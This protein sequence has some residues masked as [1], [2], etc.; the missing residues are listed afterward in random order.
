MTGSIPFPVDMKK[1]EERQKRGINYIKK[2]RGKEY[3]SIPN[4]LSF[5]NTLTYEA[6]GLLLY[7]LAKPTTWICSNA[8]LMK[9]SPAGRHKVQRILKELENA[10]YIT[11]KKKKNSEGMFY[12]ETWIYDYPHV[13]ESNKDDK[14]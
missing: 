6:R 2:S 12:Y 11:R 10:N 3:A 5:D 7:L 4:S 9:Q 13:I 14:K 1:L 8:D